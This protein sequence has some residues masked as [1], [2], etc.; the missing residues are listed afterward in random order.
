[1]RGGCSTREAP[2]AAP[3]HLPKRR[4]R[5]G[6]QAAVAA[7]L[8]R[9]QTAPC[10]LR[11]P[12]YVAR[13]QLPSSTRESGHY[14]N[15]QHAR[16]IRTVAALASITCPFDLKAIGRKAVLPCSIWSAVVAVEHLGPA[17]RKVGVHF[18]PRCC[19]RLRF[20]GSSGRGGRGVV[21]EQRSEGLPKPSD[22]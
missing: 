22:W 12:R 20:A 5:L 8:R 1:M 9:G 13:R 11:R 6:L 15:V 16:D 17:E 18:I 21:L 2:R 10:S 19:H 7:A 14:A 4:R 3:V